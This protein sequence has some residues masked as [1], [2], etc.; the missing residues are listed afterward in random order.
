MYNTLG[1]AAKLG[2]TPAELLMRS[3][4]ER[5]CQWTAGGR[6]R[7]GQ[8]SMCRSADNRDHILADMLMVEQSL[9]LVGSEGGHTQAW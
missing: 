4:Q 8:R 2:A 7:N 3:P 5:Q 1:L 6:T 9:G